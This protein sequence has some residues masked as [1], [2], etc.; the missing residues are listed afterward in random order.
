MLRTLPILLLSILTTRL[1]AQCGYTASLRTNKDYCLG[2]SLVVNT[3]HTLERIVWYKDGQR[4]D[5]ALAKQ[6]FPTNP[7]KHS[8]VGDTPYFELV[9]VILIR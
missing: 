3:K 5:S 7:I 2:S 4:I 8:I 9:C 1:C 6:S